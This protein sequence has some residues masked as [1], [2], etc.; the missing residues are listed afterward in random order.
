M[1]GII[2]L[3]ALILNP[4]ARKRRAARLDIEAQAD[5]DS[6]T[7]TLSSPERDYSIE[8]AD[9]DDAQ[10]DL[11]TEPKDSESGSIIAEEPR[12]PIETEQIEEKPAER[13]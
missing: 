8:S 2:V 3:S 13:R 11:S 6:E 9:A 12:T 7:S 1:D 5:N 4:I 10:S